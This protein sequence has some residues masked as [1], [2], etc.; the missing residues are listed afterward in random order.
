VLYFKVA[1]ETGS[2]VFRVNVA[3][4]ALGSGAAVDS[5]GSFENFD[6]RFLGALGEAG[7]CAMVYFEDMR[8]WG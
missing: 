3:R 2:K 5:V 6:G 8:V 4:G 1:P 7:G